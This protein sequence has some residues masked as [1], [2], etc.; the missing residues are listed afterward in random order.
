[1]INIDNKLSK[2]EFKDVYN[3]SKDKDVLNSYEL[4]HKLITRGLENYLCFYLNDIP[5][6]VIIYYRIN[7]GFGFTQLRLGDRSGKIPLI[8][9]DYSNKI[10]FEYILDKIN[11]IP[12]FRDIEIK[13]FSPKDELFYSILKKSNFKLKENY[14]CIIKNENEQELF[15]GFSSKCRNSIRK[16]YKNK[17]KFR[18]KKD[19]DGF[20]RLCKNKDYFDLKKI[21]KQIL[22][23]QENLD[24]LNVYKDKEILASAVVIKLK[25]RIT[26]K[27]LVS[28]EEGNAMCANNFLIWEMIKHYKNKEINLGS[29]GHETYG[30]ISGYGKFKLSFSPKVVYEPYFVK[31]NYSKIIY[32]TLLKMQE[33]VT[34]FNKLFKF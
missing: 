24:F 21:K 16:A 20:Y 10:L 17:L 28:S 13:I 8:N 32:T 2:L 5:V 23:Y 3:K 31:D 33:L 12:N 6:A 19:L 26:L 22:H 7:L 25:D 30:D 1:M 18:L 4:N 14:S 34:R 15:K 29:L 11:E 9:E 27:Y